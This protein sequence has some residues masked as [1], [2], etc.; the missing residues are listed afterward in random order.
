MPCEALAQYMHSACVG[1][2][3]NLVSRR[4]ALA[5]YSKSEA[6]LARAFSYPVQNPPTSICGQVFWPFQAPFGQPPTVNGTYCQ[7]ESIEVATT[8][9]SLLLF[10]FGY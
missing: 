8:T 9:E 7:Q 2:L 3:I 1:V 5:T 6:R 4:P 10:A